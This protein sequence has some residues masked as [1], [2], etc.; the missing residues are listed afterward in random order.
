MK[1]QG[2]VQ[3][4][5]IRFVTQFWKDK[6]VN[7]KGFIMKDGSGL[8]PDDKVSPRQLAEI[9]RAYLPDSM[10]PMFYNACLLQVCRALSKAYSKALLPKII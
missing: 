4:N 3:H 2:L 8:S 1:K 9:M 5:G 6:G 7:L 10:F